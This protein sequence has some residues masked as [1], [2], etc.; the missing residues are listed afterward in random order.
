MKL[1]AIDT[2]EDSCSVALT[3]DGQVTS[4]FELAPRRHSE[5]ILPMMDSILAE[6]GLTPGALTAVAFACGPGSFTGLR[7]SAGVAQG[8]AI[9]ADIPV[10]PVS[11]L[12]ALAQ[13]AWREHQ[14]T[15]VLAAF[16]ARMEELYWGY[17]ECIDGLMQPL[18]DEAVSRPEQLPLAPAGQWV[19]IGSGWDSYQAALTPLIGAELSVVYGDARVHAL[20]VLTLAVAD[21]NAG[22]AVE[23]EAAVPV[24]LRNNVAKKKA[25][26]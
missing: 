13:R 21:F 2:T 17:Y 20:D 5:L 1:L 14:A 18:M 3:V 4:T 7:I 16:D 25:F 22:K 19:G 6:A 12:R 23:A 9:A 26:Q 24:Y 15:Q 11:S 8:V 10:L